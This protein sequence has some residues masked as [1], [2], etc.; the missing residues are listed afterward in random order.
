LTDGALVTLRQDNRLLLLSTI[1]AGVVFSK[2]L[3]HIEQVVYFKGRVAALRARR[4]QL[5]ARAGDF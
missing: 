4:V 3:S 1:G 2:L 5:E